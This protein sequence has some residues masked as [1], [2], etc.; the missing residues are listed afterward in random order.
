MERIPGGSP[1]DSCVLDGVILN[2]DVLHPKMKRRI[3]QPRILLLDCP[4]EYG[5]GESQTAIEM[6][7]VADFDAYLKVEESYIKAT[8]DAIIALKPDVVCTEKVCDLFMQSWCIGFLI[9]CVYMLIFLFVVFF[10]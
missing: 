5:K 2:K 7:D 4:L 1:E 6:T 10:G 8:C 9:G 3:E